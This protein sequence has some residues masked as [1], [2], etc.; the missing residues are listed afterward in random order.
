VG[1][2]GG[3]VALFL[4]SL[5]LKGFKSFA[6]K[7]VIDFEPG[8]TVVVGPNGSGK[9]NLVDAV[10]WVLGAQGARTLR[11]GKMEDVI[12]A[13]TPK[14]PSLGRAEV[15]LAI[16][17]ASG[18]LPIEFSEVTITRTLFRNGDSE[19][20]INGVPCRLLDVQELLSDSGIGRQQH[21]II[22]Q[23][24]ID[25]VLNSKPE[26]RRAVIEEAAGVL[27]YRK[28]KERAERRL[29]A[30][31][32]NLVRLN[33]LLRE[34][35]R[36]LTPLARQADAARRHGGLVEE[37][38]AI[39]LHLAGKELA[40]L[41]AKQERLA[42]ER[43][44]LGADDSKLGLRLRDLDVEV[45][46]AEQA[47][48]AFGD[49]D[50]GEQ[51]VRVEKM[52]ERARGFAALL[53]ERQRSIERELA[54]VAD[55]GVVETLVAE[56]ASLRS[57]ISTLDLE[58]SQLS[59]E[60][61][62]LEAEEAELERER[63][64][65]RGDDDNENVAEE[66]AVVRKELA[67][68]RDALH[69]AANALERVQ[70]RLESTRARLVALTEEREALV[71]ELNRAEADAPSLQEMAQLAEEQRRRAESNLE[72]AEAR[73]LRTAGE[74]GHWRARA[75]ALALALATERAASNAEQ[76]ADVDGVVGPLVD[77]L[78]I[79]AGAEAAVGAVLGN[80]LRAVVV[81]GG[82]A[83]RRAIEKLA[84]GDAHAMLLVLDDADAGGTQGRM[85]PPGT[86]ALSDFVRA[87]VAGLDAA[88]ERAFGNTVLVEGDWRVAL[89]IAIANR[90]VT[91]V[92]RDG[93]SFGG[94][95]PWS[96]G[97][98]AV[99][100]TQAELDEALERAQRADESHAE[101]QTAVADARTALEEAKQAERASSD[102]ARANADVL[103]GA[104]QTL[105]R[106]DDERRTRATETDALEAELHELESNRVADAEAV[107]EL[108]VRLPELEAAEQDRA[109]RL[110][111]RR[112]A[113]ARVAE[114][115]HKLRARRRDLELRSAQAD[116]RRAGLTRR[117]ADVEERLARQPDAQ[118]KAERRR[119]ELGARSQAYGAIA[120][121]LS[122]FLAQVETL[123][124]R[125]RD[126]RRAQTEAAREATERLEG[127]RRDRAELEKE[128]SETR[129]RAQRNEIE[130]A[131]TKLRLETLVERIRTELEIEPEKALDAPAPEVPEGMTLSSRGR[132]LERELRL[133]GPINPLA[134]QEYEELQERHAFLDAQLDDVKQSRRELQ[135]VIKAVDAEIVTVFEEAFAD[136]AEHF[137]NLFA[138]LFPGGQGRVFLTDP[139]DPL[140]T[141]IEMEARPSG[142]QVRRLSL[143]SGGERT[144]TA[145]AFLFAVFRARPSPFYLLDEVEA[146][147]DDVNLQ[148]FLD[149]IDEFRNEAQLLIVSHQKRTMEAGDMLYGVSMP[150]G[151]STRVVAQRMA[152]VEPAAG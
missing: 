137:S 124:E 42:G 91:A 68:R 26:D 129:E 84:Q 12:F 14:R 126:R 64:A 70:S 24:Q 71:V 81:R 138:T 83:A 7:T 20:A 36:Q 73:Q 99:G 38:A 119:N 107:A 30:T 6:D 61:N 149:L 79:E 23:G 17:N 120:E 45:L 48:G 144:L 101:A 16:D 150:P 93:D 96:I 76:L 62:A 78:E 100:V 28:R 102:A 133:M 89:D 151:G 108:E 104:T 116:E 57:E 72:Q 118:A 41:Q 103:Q 19:Y 139:E 29:E 69:R 37:L 63:V 134:L 31:E 55:E 142:K 43:A 77:H 18:A 33:D 94:N 11:G 113:R 128:L 40:G 112:A 53:A 9:S 122:I 27:K 25:T 59:P 125:L 75:E 56:A 39:R 4:K 121:R 130:T 90:G 34:V 44:N 86:R 1:A 110:Q 3:D 58:T 141:G 87:R 145:M 97:G 8:V 15:S 92:T 95:A 22:G 136:V 131:E 10:A 85:V 127:L 74:A 152:D 146:A 46:A 5:T 50:V 82:D 111:Q 123:H 135:R 13:G 88:L 132:E 117:L 65:L 147:L 2:A 114:T 52:R 106:L 47:L 109:Q 115:D 67:S 98:G 105:T 140:N 148:R 32:G 35:R 51:L 49:D 80:M 54:S 66:A 21:V 60:F 143:L